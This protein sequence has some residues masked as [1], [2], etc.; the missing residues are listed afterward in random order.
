MQR[1]FDF[2]FCFFFLWRFLCAEMQTINEFLFLFTILSLSFPLPFTF[3]SHA[4]SHI[5]RP[6]LCVFWRLWTHFKV[7]QNIS[8]FHFPFFPDIIC[9]NL[10]TF[11]ATYRTHLVASYL[12]LF[13][14]LSPSPAL[15]LLPA[16]I[17]FNIPAC[18]QVG[19]FPLK[20]SSLSLLLLLFVVVC[21]CWHH[22]L[23]LENYPAFPS[24]RSLPFCI[25]MSR[26]Q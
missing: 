17:V 2:L 5:F 21:C 12:C 14:S 7:T 3:C 1:S 4:D 18:C 20:T 25:F 16:I 19:N 15:F 26:W 13:L 24:M 8:Q 9:G 11:P 6:L 22:N 23:W 10:C